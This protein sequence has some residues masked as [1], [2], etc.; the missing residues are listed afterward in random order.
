MSYY[1]GKINNNEFLILKN[2]NK[3]KFSFET[4]CFQGTKQFYQTNYLNVLNIDNFIYNL[5]IEIDDYLKKNRSE[6]TNYEL[7][8]NIIFNNKQFLQ[9]KVDKNV[10]ILPDTKLFLDIEVD[11]IKLNKNNI[12]EIVLKLINF[13]ILT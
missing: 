8:S 4:T 12:Y 6:F 3:I 1:I 7:K 5:E 9:F 13:K 2:Q 10:N 11:K